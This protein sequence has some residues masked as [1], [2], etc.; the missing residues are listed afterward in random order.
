MF[1]QND[2]HVSSS[3]GR[4]PTLSDLLRSANAIPTTTRMADDRPTSGEAKNKRRLL[5]NS[6]SV[7]VRSWFGSH[8][9]TVKLF[10]RILSAATILWIAWHT[11][12]S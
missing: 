2:S 12:G 11:I 6:A 5:N 1:M 9:S 8:P 4:I 7:W 10:T 3:G